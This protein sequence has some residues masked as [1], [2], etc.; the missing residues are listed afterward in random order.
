MNYPL[1]RFFSP[2]RLFSLIVFFFALQFN[3]FIMPQELVKNYEKLLPQEFIKNPAAREQFSALIEAK[4]KLHPELIYYYITYYNMFFSASTDSAKAEYSKLKRYIFSLESGYTNK[5]SKWAKEQIAQVKKMNLEPDIKSHIIEKFTEL[6]LP[7]SGDIPSETFQADE[8]QK[9][10][11]TAM[12]FYGKIFSEYMTD[13]Q[14]K[15]VLEKAKEEKK[16]ELILLYKNAVKENK[17]SKEVLSTFFDHWYLFDPSVTPG[18]Q[19]SCPSVAAIAAE[20]SKENYS[21]RHVS[22]FSAG[23]TIAPISLGSKVKPELFIKGYKQDM[24]F[25]VSAPFK[26]FGLSLGYKYHLRDNMV[27]FSYINFQ[28]HYLTLLSKPTVSHSSGFSKTSTVSEQTISE[29]LTFKKFDI[30][31]VTDQSIFLRISTPVYTFFN[32]FTAE[33]GLIGGM[34]N[35]KYELD[36]NYLYLKR[37]AHDYGTGTDIITAGSE[38][39]KIENSVKKYIFSPVIALKYNPLNYLTAG[40]DMTLNN[41]S[42]LVLFEF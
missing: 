5:R 20:L 9:D 29:S 21:I 27:I 1:S 23:L 39:K 4:S 34:N 13:T 3:S 17:R 6:V 24:T 32:V 18:N 2:G 41:F 7:Y 35:L 11:Y 31:P 28:V 38:K 16:E 26:Q 40:A 22:H 42:L 33:V 36:Y 10:F 30:T 37:G 8:N 19:S 12:Y 15:P 25:E 14:F